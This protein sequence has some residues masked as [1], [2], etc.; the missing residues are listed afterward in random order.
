MLE[1]IK[2]KVVDVYGSMDTVEKITCSI[3]LATMLVVIVF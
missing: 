1:T 3:C 2:T